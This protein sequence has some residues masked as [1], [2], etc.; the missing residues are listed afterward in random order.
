MKDLWSSQKN[1][2]KMLRS[3][4]NKTRRRDMVTQIVTHPSAG[5]ENALPSFRSLTKKSNE[6]SRDDI[7]L[8]VK[9]SFRNQ[10]VG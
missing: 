1:A 3:L 4:V 6:F 2:N 5:T 9:L 7:L 8:H 10:Y